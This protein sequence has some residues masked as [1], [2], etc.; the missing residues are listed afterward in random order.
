MSK[1]PFDLDR[2]TGLIRVFP[3]GPLEEDDFSA[4]SEEVE[5]FVDGGGALRGLVIDTEHFPG[6]DDFGAFLAHVRFIREHHR[7]IPKVAVISDDRL[8]STMPGIADHFVS[9]TVRH[10]PAA[11]RENALAWVVSRED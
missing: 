7:M 6:W 11:E 10:F 8:L 4:L 2:E 1:L 5:A 3:Q 9:A